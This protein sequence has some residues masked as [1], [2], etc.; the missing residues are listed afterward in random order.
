MSSEI[1]PL[2]IDPPK[3]SMSSN[4]SS[5]VIGIDVGGT[6]T[7]W[8]AEFLFLL[9]LPSDTFDS[10]ILEGEQV[11]AWHK[12]PTTSDIQK[13]VENA[14]D[15]VVKKANV[16]PGSIDAVKIGTTVRLAILHRDAA[17]CICPW[18]RSA[19]LGNFV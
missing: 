13:G 8:Q 18:G 2:S 9:P 1:L 17:L 12:T 11:V 3:S 15:A 10:V 4:V 5:C 14:I 6:N 19:T 16:A 7:D